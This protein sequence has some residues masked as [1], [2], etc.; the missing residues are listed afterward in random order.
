M[1]VKVSPAASRRKNQ[2]GLTLIELLIVLFIL[3]AVAGVTIGLVPNVQKRTHGSTSAASIRAGETALAAELFTTGRLGGGFDGLITATGDI[4]DY[5]GETAAEGF[6]AV[7][8]TTD[9]VDALNDLGIDEVY[10]AAADS[11]ANLLAGG[12]ENATFDGHDYTSTIAIS[13]TNSIAALGAT[14][15]G[16]VEEAFNIS[17]AYSD[18]GDQIFAFGLGSRSDIVGANKSFKLAPV[19]TP[20][21]GSAATSYSRYAILVGYDDSEG[22][23]TFIGMTCIDDGSEF[24]SIDGNLAEFL[25]ATN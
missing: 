7:A 9:S 23:A 25:E 10:E 15:V 3:A 19:H 8:L 16:E 4:P 14:S 2:Q 6:Q 1:K 17:G 11:F 13:G 21:E 20:G 5:V 24:K 12:G 18:A 22:E